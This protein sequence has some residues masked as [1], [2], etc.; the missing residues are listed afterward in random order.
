MI[1][2]R[3]SGLAMKSIKILTDYESVAKAP[4]R[5][6]TS[7]ITVSLGFPTRLISIHGSLLLLYWCVPAQIWLIYLFIP[8][9]KPLTLRSPST[10][11]AISTR[12]SIYCIVSRSGCNVN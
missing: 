2:G 12:V 5:T 4:M 7:T 9:R 6:V 11:A 10:W 3:R 1:D 8:D